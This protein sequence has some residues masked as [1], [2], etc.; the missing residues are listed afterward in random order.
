MIEEIVKRV[1]DSKPSLLD[2][3][4]RVVFFNMSTSNLV[5]ALC[6]KEREER[7]RS[8]KRARTSVEAL[9][10]D[11]NDDD[12]QEVPSISSSISSSF[13]TLSS[14]TLTSTILSSSS[15]SSSFSSWPLRLR[16]ASISVLEIKSEDRA[17]VV[18]GIAQ[19]AN[20]IG[21]LNLHPHDL[22]SVE[23]RLYEL[24][25]KCAAKASM[26]SQN[27]SSSSSSRS[28]S[29]ALSCALW[30]DKNLDGVRV[31]LDSE[32][33]SRTAWQDAVITYGIAGAGAVAL[34][35]VN[36]VGF[37]LSALGLATRV[38][39]KDVMEELART[40]SREFGRNKSWN[41]DIDNP[42]KLRVQQLL[43]N[44]YGIERSVGQ[45]ETKLRK[46]TKT[47][48][49]REIVKERGWFVPCIVLASLNA[50]TFDEKKTLLSYLEGAC[51]P[52][53]VNR[54]N[55]NSFVFVRSSHVETSK[56]LY[57]FA[58]IS[59]DAMKALGEARIVA[60]AQ[61]QQPW[62]YS[63]LIELSQSK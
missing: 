2:S 57:Q 50:E 5:L 8:R 53:W 18:A 24:G 38:A 15:S 17:A 44:I 21:V 32:S 6:A 27:S 61:I 11:D 62:G 10:I 58:G 47:K 19:G 36:G 39:T 42:K 29:V 30:I 9:V 48:K 43:M 37:L 22:E 46:G 25:F 12:V 31:Q 54:S 41:D 13:S 45:F 33:S 49:G 16:V 14:A 52:K 1:P 3:I 56:D 55:G 59:Q 23:R 20:A 40:L 4:F 51:G 7:E 26:A 63:A 35:S 60:N 28:N 34:F